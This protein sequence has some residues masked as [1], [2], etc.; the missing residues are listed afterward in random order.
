VQLEI[1]SL[2]REDLAAVHALIAHPSMSREFEN[3]LPPA[4]LEEQ[5]KDPWFA[6]HLALLGRADGQPAGWAMGFVSPGEHG[7]AFLRIGV[8]LPWRRRGIGS[9]LLR[10]MLDGLEAS[11]TMRGLNELVLS[12]WLPNDEAA[13]FAAHHGFR[14]V[15]FFWRMDRP[16]GATLAPPCWPAEVETRPLAGDDMLR[17]WNDAYNLSFAA[18]YHFV[19]ST[20]E[21]VRMRMETDAFRNGG[22]L[23]AYRG[24]KCVGFC[25][26]ALHGRRGEVALVGVVPAA[27]GIGLGR[28]L[29]RWGV[30]WIEARDTDTVEL[31]V[32]GENE[33]A[34]AL[35]RSEGFTVA[36]TREVWS[37]PP[38]GS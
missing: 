28:A 36:R 22:I 19:P 24:G 32:D 15:R 5:W 21:A 27:R 23:L 6:P 11:G 30:G 26:D 16:R 7:F 12:G 34:L 29:L 8:A 13:A 1:R 33:T 18:H 14:H 38:G 37:R 31:Q 20:L 9:A 10:R 17:A 4:A 2:G 25:H 3:L 35:Y